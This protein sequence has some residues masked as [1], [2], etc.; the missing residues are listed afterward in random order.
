MQWISTR[1]AECNDSHVT[2]A[3]RRTILKPARLLQIIADGT[4]LKIHLCSA[5][6]VERYAAVSYCW[7]DVQQT[8][9]TSSVQ[10]TSD[11]GL[12]I[13][14]LPASLADALDIARRIGLNFVWIDSLCII[15][16][17][18]QDKATEIS[19]MAAI[20]E[21]AFITISA[22]SAERCTDGFLH[23][24]IRPSP[25]AGDSFRLP[26]AQQQP[27]IVIMDGDLG[28]V[29]TWAVFDRRRGP[30]TSTRWYR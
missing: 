19:K 15:Q 29:L 7:G 23:H 27:F 9:S 21:H 26:S 25:R 14:E 12:S 3:P 28:R 10:E 1:L 13:S 22:G 24:L 30:V 11:S 8:V 20:Y 6:R 5:T 2:C 4:T 16:S 18:A 17:D